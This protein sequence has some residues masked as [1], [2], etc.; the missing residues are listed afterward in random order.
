[1]ALESWNLWV[2]FM[3]FDMVLHGF[4]IGLMI[5]FIWFYMVLYGWLYMVSWHQ[6][7]I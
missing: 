2:G 1:M 4:I 5:G 3:W 7:S 6:I